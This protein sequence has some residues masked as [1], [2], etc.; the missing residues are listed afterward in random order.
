GITFGLDVVAFGMMPAGYHLT[1]LLLHA[2]NTALFYLAARRLLGL[3]LPAAAARAAPLGAATAALV[4]AL[5][6]LRAESVAWVTERRDV[7]SGFFFFLTLIAYLR[8]GDA[9]V[10]RGPWLAASVGCYALSML[11]KPIVMSLPFVLV[12]LDFY[13]LARLSPRWREWL[14]PGARAAWAEKLP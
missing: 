4:F 9:E 2:A 10:R 1:N 8:A 5:H 7:L 12:I 13:P 6:P 14:S 3:A 11:A